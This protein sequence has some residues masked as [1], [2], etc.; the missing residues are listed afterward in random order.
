MKIEQVKQN[1]EP[2]VITL[3]TKEELE[4]FRLVVV[5]AVNHSIEESTLEEFALD[6]ETMLEHVA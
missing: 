4:M 3:T 5:T 6:M 2:V 1:F